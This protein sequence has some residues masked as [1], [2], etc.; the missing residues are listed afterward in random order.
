M[1]IRWQKLKSKRTKS[2]FFIEVT[3]M[4]RVKNRFQENKLAQEIYRFQKTF[5]LMNPKNITD[6]ESVEKKIRLDQTRFRKFRILLKQM[7]KRLCMEKW[8]KLAGIGIT[9]LIRFKIQNNLNKN[10]PI[11]RK[12]SIKE[13]VFFFMMKIV[14]IFHSCK[15]KSNSK[16]KKNNLTD[17]DF[18]SLNWLCINFKINFLILKSKMSH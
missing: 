12:I 15:E 11:V 8:I 3:L 17:Q 4:W 9:N 18:N 1:R 10:N 6:K 14:E 2:K 7:L 13:K 16:F 5:I